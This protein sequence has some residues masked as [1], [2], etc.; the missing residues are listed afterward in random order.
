MALRSD[1]GVNELEALPRDAMRLKRVAM[2]DFDVGIVF[3]AKASGYLGLLPLLTAWLQA[4]RRSA[5]FA[6]VR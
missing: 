1:P 6:P 4:L 5:G 3:R 2:T